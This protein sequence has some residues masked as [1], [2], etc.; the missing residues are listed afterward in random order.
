MEVRTGALIVAWLLARAGSF[1][2][3]RGFGQF[4]RRPEAVTKH[5]LSFV[6]GPA[7]IA[8]L[9][10]RGA[11]APA[12]AVTTT[13]TRAAAPLTIAARRQ[14]LCH[15]EPLTVTRPSLSYGRPD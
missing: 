4:L 6:V 2:V 13:T 3:G 10:I 5:T 1:E 14:R 8:G 15:G 11:E 7:C 12:A 9:R